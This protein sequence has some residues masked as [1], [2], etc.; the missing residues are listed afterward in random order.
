M[1]LK[2]SVLSSFLVALVSVAAPGCG[3]EPANVAGSYTVAVT[4]GS[5]GC[6][7]D[8][9]VE[10]DTASGIPVTITQ[11]GESA[12][13]VVEG[14]TALGLGLLFGSNQF[15]GEVSGSSLN[16]VVYGSNSITEGNCTFTYNGVIDAELTGDV[17]TGEIR[18]EA[19]TV[20]NPDCAGIEGC[21]TVQRFNGTRPPT[22]Q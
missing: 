4:N 17:L 14:V 10:G 22:V 11:T 5:N 7:F 19:A 18:Y 1:A 9:W 3:G 8:N 21:V 15:D 16:L 20:G 13:A 12:S 2:T 6:S